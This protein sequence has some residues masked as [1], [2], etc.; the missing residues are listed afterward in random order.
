MK[1]TIGIIGQGFVGETLY[2]K[3][4]NY[5][6]VLTF[7]IDNSKSNSTLVKVKNCKII[8]LCLP[9]P[10]DIDGSCDLSILEEV[11]KQI[12]KPNKILVIKS[13]II[14]GSTDYFNKKYESD[15][16]F[17]PEFLRE[18]FAKSDFEK[19]SH[20]IL[21][22]VKNIALKIKSIYKKVF[23]NKKIVITD[24]ITSEMVKYTIN[25]FLA[26]K[27]SYANEINGL[28]NKL[29]LSYEELM[30]IAK[31]DSRIGDSHWNVP[32]HDGDYGYGGALPSKRPKCTY[33][34]IRST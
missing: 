19:Q 23:K 20:I 11:I 30:K 18:K 7:D 8:F 3:F 26:V 27:V 1:N 24:A 2:Y 32:G 25:T 29:S 33:K 12:D 31:F 28:C 14:P 13:T 9:T 17:N 15:F 6:N 4:K 34:S 10:M 22:G 16:I 5:Y 21:G